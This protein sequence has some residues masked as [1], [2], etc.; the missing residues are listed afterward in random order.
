MKLCPKCNHSPLPFLMVFVVA[1]VS[2][3]VTWLTV[4]LSIT[5]PTP[6][7]AA[8]ALA[9]VV[10]GWA[11][12]HYVLSCLRRHCRHDERS[13]ARRAVLGLPGQP[14]DDRP[15]SRLGAVG[16]AAEI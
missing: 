12:L 2:A 4:G 16:A 5:Q 11:L 3:F 8:S 15:A 1:S 9:F 7:A 14:G 6:R 10:V 13:A